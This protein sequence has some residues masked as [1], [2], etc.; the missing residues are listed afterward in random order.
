MKA[1]REE[2]MYPNLH[3]PLFKMSVPIFIPEATHKRELV[4]SDLCKASVC[5]KSERLCNE[6]WYRQSPGVPP[7]KGNYLNY[8][9]KGSL[10]CPPVVGLREAQG[11]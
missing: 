11:R 5:P 1:S 6:D 4:F 3:S 10:L 8:L 7:T 2:N 9:H